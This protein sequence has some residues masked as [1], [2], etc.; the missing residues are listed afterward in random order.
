M[1]STL[2]NQYTGTD[3]NVSEYE[4]VFTNSPIPGEQIL[5]G[6][7]YATNNVIAEFRGEQIIIGQLPPTGTDNPLR[8]LL[9]T[10]EDTYNVPL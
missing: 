3:V 2:L 10:K 8:L 5:I 7:N 1:P 6:Y 4:V 9:T